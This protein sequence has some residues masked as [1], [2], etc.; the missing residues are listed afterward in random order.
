MTRTL[1]IAAFALVVACAEAPAN[2]PA[3]MKQTKAPRRLPEQWNLDS[4]LASRHVPDCQADNIT[5][6]AIAFL[7]QDVECEFRLEIDEAGKVR[8]ATLSRRQPPQ[9][10]ERLLEHAKTCVELITFARPPHQPYQMNTVVKCA[11]RT[12]SWPE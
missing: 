9:G 12:R 10:H 8:E 4:P 11:A 5:A 7:K 6:E 1:Q 2:P 3:Q